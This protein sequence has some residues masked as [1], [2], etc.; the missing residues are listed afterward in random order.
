V[1]KIWAK[2]LVNHRVKKGIIFE[3]GEEYSAGNFFKYIEAI[4]TILKNPTPVILKKHI[5]EFENFNTTKFTAVDF[6]EEIN[7]DKLVIENA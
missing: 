7:F 2:L 6:V 5:N 4:C 1:L 3:A